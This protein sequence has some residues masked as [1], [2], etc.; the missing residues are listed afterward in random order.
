MAGGLTPGGAPRV[1]DREENLEG[2]SQCRTLTAAKQSRL[3]RKKAV[4]RIRRLRS[5]RY[6]DGHGGSRRS[7]A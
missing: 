3:E 1:A 4:A 6:C 7:R 5:V 2:S